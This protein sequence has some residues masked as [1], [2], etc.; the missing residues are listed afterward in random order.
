MPAS[1]K[2]NADAK[3][4]DTEKWYFRYSYAPF[5]YKEP[6][7]NAIMN[8]KYACDG[9]VA[10]AFAPLLAKCFAGE[11][12][13]YDMMIPVPLAKNRARQ[14]GYNQAE[15]LARE[16]SKFIE[17]VVEAQ[18]LVK[19]KNTIPQEDMTTE[20]RRENQKDAFEVVNREL[21]KGKKILLV[22]DVFTSGST[23]NECAR[24]LKRAGV[25]Y[26]DVVVV[27]RVGR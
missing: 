6:L 27:A 15:L 25:K 1:V 8:L 4:G 18:F 9:V 19:T 21:I 3:S 7:S 17:V 23:V 20:Q 22:D 5:F 12:I 14:R 10:E 24:V 13:E 16:L 26:V 11:N 2:V